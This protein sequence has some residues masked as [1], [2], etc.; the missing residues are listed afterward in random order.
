MLSPE[1]QG[2]AFYTK[3]IK[4]YLETY[5][6]TGGWQVNDTEQGCI[7]MAFVQPANPDY[8]AIGANGGCVRPSSGYAF[9]FIQKQTD[10]VIDRLIRKGPDY[11]TL[12][13][14]P[15]PIGKFDLFLDRIF[16]ACYPAPS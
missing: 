5:W 11:L 12:A 16:C 7:P 4:T 13:T 14:L 9:A 8:L 2:D 15:Q 3:A 10:A 1:R 6:N